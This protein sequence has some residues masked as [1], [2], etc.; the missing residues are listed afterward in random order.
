MQNDPRICKAGTGNDVVRWIGCGTPTGRRTARNTKAGERRGVE[1][2]GDYY[3]QVRIT[4]ALDQLRRLCGL[5]C[6]MEPLEMSSNEAEV[7][8]AKF[9]VDGNP[10]VPDSHWPK[11]WIGDH[12]IRKEVL[13]LNVRYLEFRNAQICSRNQDIEIGESN[14]N[15]E[16]AGSFGFE[17][18]Q[19][20]NYGV[21]LT[22]RGQRSE[23]RTKRVKDFGV[24]MHEQRAGAPDTNF[25]KPNQV[26][27][28]GRNLVRDRGCAFR[29]VAGLDLQV[30]S[31]NLNG[32]ILWRCCLKYRAK[33]CAFIQVSSHDRQ[34]PVSVVFG[35]GWRIERMEKIKIEQHSFM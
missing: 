25:L 1:I 19:D 2:S 9:S 15:A 29:D 5:Y 16:R 24:C 23:K 34:D 26:G 13:R 33:V 28:L 7:L 35:N 22:A 20:G 12:Q 3:R 32:K 14:L 17:F 11:N 21:L 4:W 31:R 6:R 18:L 10:A 27:L 30:S 8:A